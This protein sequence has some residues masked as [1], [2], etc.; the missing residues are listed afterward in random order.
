MK[1]IAVFSISVF[2]ILFFSCNKNDTPKDEN[3]PFI[4]LLGSNPIYSE[5]GK[6]YNDPGAEAYDITST[7]DTVDITSR[8][9]V[10]DN[11]DINTEGEYQVHYNVSDESGNRADEK[12][13]TVYVR[14]F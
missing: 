3:P 13:R 11:V 4:V 12:I 6:P 9:Q 7:G 8:L 1:V 5:L 14:I 10:T 2:F